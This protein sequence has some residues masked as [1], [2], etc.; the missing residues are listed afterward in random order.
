MGIY[1]ELPK[2]LFFYAVTSI[3]G[4]AIGV[5]LGFFW[6]EKVIPFIGDLSEN[7]NV[8]PEWKGTITFESDKIWDATLTIKKGGKKI[9]GQLLLLTGES[10]GKK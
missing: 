6:K 3:L 4:S 5:I 7:T 1:E 10:A 9:S 2:Q 8:H